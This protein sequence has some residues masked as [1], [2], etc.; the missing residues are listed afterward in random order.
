MVNIAYMKVHIFDVH[1]GCFF[2]YGNNN[3][4]VRG[5]LSSHIEARL[6][7]ALTAVD[8]LLDLV[9]LVVLEFW[10]HLFDLKSVHHCIR[11]LEL[12]RSLGI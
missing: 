6:G 11:V 9:D 5:F 8:D 4:F 3:L 7:F 1:V 2:V 12:R 10:E